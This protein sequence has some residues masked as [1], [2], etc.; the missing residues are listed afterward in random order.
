MR[1]RKLEEEQPLLARLKTMLFGRQQDVFK[2]SWA[3][4]GGGLLSRALSQGRAVF[5]SA[6]PWQACLL[7]P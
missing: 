3:P 6:A 2:F 4:L 1:G 7:Q 5:T